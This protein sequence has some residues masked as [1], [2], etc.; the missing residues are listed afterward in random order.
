MIDESP[1][2]VLQEN[3]SRKN[4]RNLTLTTLLERLR[5]KM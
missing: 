5:G 2:V 4:T 3:T 1:I